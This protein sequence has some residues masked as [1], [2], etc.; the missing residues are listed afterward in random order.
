LAALAALCACAKTV[1][2]AAGI[3]EPCVQNGDCAA[4][5][6][7]ASSRCSLP[8]NL[9]GCE[10]NAARCNGADVER[11]SAGGLGW[12]HVTTCATG[13][14]AGACRPQVCTPG[15]QRCEGDAAEACS[16]SGDAWALVQQCATHCNPDTGRCRS[17]SCAPFSA[18]CDPGGANAVWVCDAYGGG[19]VVTAC[20]QN[21]VC[22]GGTCVSSSAGC[23]LEDVRCNGRDA[24]VCVSG[25][26]GTT[27]WQTRETCLSACNGGVCDG[28]GACASVALHAAAAV[29]PADGRSTVLFYSDPIQSA[30]GLALPDGQE[31]T[32][33]AAT[34]GATAEAQIASADADPDLPG[35]QVKSV[36]GRVKFTVLAPL[37]A[38]S[39]AL[40]TAQA[41]LVAGA[42]CGA[43][44]QLTFAAGASQGVLVAEDFTARAAAVAGGADWN[45][46]RGAL[47]A[48]FPRPVGDGRDGAL[49]VPAGTSL[50]LSTTSL[51]PAYQVLQLG[52]TSA[53]VNAAQAAL[54]GGDEVIL[55]DAQGV[56][57]AAA[58]A[59]GYEFLTVQSV[60]GDSATFS[61][62]VRGFYGTGA[63]QAV[64]TQRVVLQRVPRLSSLFIGPGATLTAPAWDGSKGGLLFLRVSGAA[65]VQGDIDMDGK[66]FRGASALASFAEGMNGFNSGGGA[67]FGAGGGGYGAAG[68]GSNAGG[69]YGTA[70]LGVLHLGAGGGCTSACAP[71]AGRGGGAIV[72]SARTLS[73]QSGTSTSWVGKLHAAG[74][75][76]AGMSGGAGG[77]L[78][79]S[80]GSVT[81]G[82]G[83]AGSIA[84]PGAGN[85][86]AGRIRLDFLSPSPTG[87]AVACAATTPSAACSLGT[88]GALSAQS[89]DAFVIDSLAAVNIQVAKLELALGAPAGAVYRA[90]AADPPDFS[91]PLA[92]GGSVQFGVGPNPTVG[93]RFRWRAELSPDPGTTQLLLGLQWSLQVY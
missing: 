88:H 26:P 15:A 67:G 78:W 27:R 58:N 89:G 65:V 21:E 32:V 90:S 23:R 66:G 17:P 77:S 49:S 75:S 14:T 55:W 51:A 76:Q 5:F 39:D 29:A 86:G 85:G 72:I 54:Q 42:T 19:Y 3:G 33:S 31:F 25:A 79:V 48:T 60:S 6:I 44:A 40:V 30:G 36:G 69:S 24:Q 74:K 83:S 84:A 20:A 22:N 73:L 63:D 92:Q 61:T 2:A 45:T 70:T 93:K 41:R 38:S 16:P 1:P 87:V 13:C 47:V 35:V 8:A 46:A 91:V 7:C 59:G 80:A 11:C 62:A 50:D 4:G 12:D 68:S 37:A 52:A 10:P 82:D 64:S 71:D 81:L 34:A 18:R 53:R 9:G 56:A 43:A 57:A 28:A